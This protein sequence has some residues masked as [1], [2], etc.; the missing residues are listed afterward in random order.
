MTNNETDVIPQKDNSTGLL[1]FSAM[2]EGE[3]EQFVQSWV[4]IPYRLNGEDRVTGLDCRTLTVKFLR[5]QGIAV[6]DTDG[7]PLPAIIEELDVIR[8]EAGIKDAG[9]TVPL[10]ELK[11]NDIVYYV[12]K[13]GR[14]HV[15]IWV[16]DDRILT[17]G[18][19]TGSFLYRASRA[20]MRG[21]VR[22]RRAVLLDDRPIDAPP[23]HDPVTILAAIG[24]AATLGAATGTTAVVIGAVVVAA[25]VASIGFGIGALSSARKSFDFES[26]GL[27]TS[28]RYS[29]DGARNIRS[30]QYP[31]PIIYSG[32]GIRIL[33][34]FEIWNSGQAAETQK[35]LVIISEGELGSITDVQLNGTDIASFTGSSFTAYTGTDTQ[36][37]D[38][39]ASGSNVVGLKNTAYL[40][41]T[42][43]ASD[44]L[45]G[46][47][48][49][50]CK[51]TGRKVARWNGTDWTT[52]AAAASGN[53][54]AVIR[55]YLTLTRERG[56]CGFPTSVIDDASFGTVY[57]YCEGTVTN[58]DS[59]TEGRARL[60]MII[61]TFRPWLDNL[62]DMMATFGGFLVT[63]G[64]KFYL[65]VEK[66]ESA[67]Q[68]FTQDNV[69]DVDYQT[70][71][72]DERPNRIIG[73]YIDPSAEG[74]DARTRV[75]VDDLVDQDKNPRG[76]VPREVA[77]LGISRQTQAIR[78]VTK[79]LSDVRANWYTI[80]FLAQ[81]DALALEA[82]DIFTLAHP[83]LGDG[84]TTYTFR[85]LRILE[86]ENHTRRII[87]KA[88]TAGIFND[89]HEQQAVTLQ[90]VGSPNPFTSVTDVT[91]LN[92]VEVVT[93][94]GDGT[95]MITVDASWT[96]PIER[97]NLKYYEVA[98]KKTTD[99]SYTVVAFTKDTKYTIVHDFEV[100]A[101]YKVRVRTVTFTDVF[102]TGLESAT[103]T[104][105]GLP[106]APANVAN[107]TSTFT[108]EI[109]FK[110]DK[111]TE[112]DLAGYEIRTEDANFGVQSAA[113]IFRGNAQTFTIVRPGS[114]T[115]GT[116]YIRAFTR[117]GRFSAASASV[118]PTNAAPA[119]P[120]VATTQWF[121]YAKLEWTDSGDSDLL[122]YEVWKSATGDFTGEEVLESRIQGTEAI[123]QGNPPVDAIAD[124]TTA[125]TMTD[126]AIAGKGT[127]YFVGDRIKQTS[128]AFSGQEA[129]VTAYNTT[130][131]Q[132]TVA[133]WPS[134]TPSVGDKFVLKDRAH[135]KVRGVDTFGN[136]SF[137]ALKTIDFTP[138]AEAEL[139]DQVITAR[140]LTTG[141][142]ITLSAQIKDAVI[143]NAKIFDLNGTKITAGTITADKLSVSTLSAITADLGTITAGT[144]TGATLRTASS[145]RRVVMDGSGVIGY[146]ASDNKRF[147]FLVANVSGFG[148][149]GDML[150]GNK[151]AGK[152]VEWDESAATLTVRGTLTADDI[153]TGTL[154]A[155]RI[156]AGSI[157]TTKV[158]TNA[159]TQ[160]ASNAGDTGSSLGSTYT[161]CG[162]VTMSTLGSTD[163]VLMATF[164]GTT[165]GSDQTVFSC[166]IVRDGANLSGEFQMSGII[167]N[168]GQG[169]SIVK[170]VAAESSGT[171]TYKIQ[172]KKISGGNPN[173]RVEGEIVA[174][175]LKR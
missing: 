30:N 26:Q 6:K 1:D 55:D 19:N 71:S 128:G 73:V 129:T 23:G 148:D 154:N 13:Y 20:R 84:V 48:I 94:L 124:A 134:G 103:L 91:G 16:G 117:S 9:A 15:G 28:P 40:A 46:D 171:H 3:Y 69:T 122:Y 142:L 89:G 92:L 35:R 4:G 149:A 27:G 167:A 8:Y 22:G 119:T 169:V 160:T 74:N 157:T 104:I 138:L 127:D 7:R 155:D 82:G 96:S 165:S 116:Y 105:T 140:K 37:V 144:V 139:G 49:I 112:A 151:G 25:T 102:S 159:I 93:V 100:G 168:G 11:R 86:G 43:Q 67:V 44:K 34:T 113:L 147:G 166:K 54:A 80:S 47:P 5:S 106:P 126:D 29:L 78:E 146:D 133:S 66:N 17:T 158:S 61:D 120:T 90:H 111:N 170:T 64:R 107:F 52:L 38:S 143:T 57:D 32:S 163:V 136:G 65:R 21:A 101:G 70:F 42:L 162:S 31:V 114:R 60:D 95:A 51:V 98:V 41:L 63:D 24:T 131:G 123:V 77:L 2:T 118:T 79:L 161:D 14:L 18:E 110:W 72:K 108:D 87:G 132:I 97:L 58:P 62:Q 174:M 115:P 130:T 12:N 53:P 121:G 36:G 175:E 68:A 76:I 39:R 125:T 135:Y 156:S 109:V 152:Y 10:N 85:A 173:N 50:T 56:G 33:N 153:T 99:A 75:S 145:G 83:I 81:A 164:L 59:S 45:S 150:I 137:S 172:A 141:E 88:Y